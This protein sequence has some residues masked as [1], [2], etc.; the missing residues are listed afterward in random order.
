MKRAVLAI[1]ALVA[2]FA[3]ANAG[4]AA[5]QGTQNNALFAQSYA[6]NNVT[7]V[8]ATT[9]RVSCY[10]PEVTYFDSLAA[11]DGYPGG[12]MTPC[13]RATT[14]EQTQG[15]ATQDVS[16]PPMLVKD[17]SESD[18]R[19]DPGNPSHVIGTSK[20]FVSAEG[21]NHLLGFYESWDGGK[22]WP[23]QGHIPGY[24][25]W[26]DNT[27]PVGAF[28]PW[29]NFYVANLP[30]EFVYSKSGGHV[31]NNGSAQANPSLPPE[32]VSVAVRPAGAT[33]ATQWIS[34]HNGVP[35]FVWTSKNANTGTPDKQWITIDDNSASPFKGRAYVMF[36]DYVL[37]PSVPLLSY[38][39]TRRDGSHT[40][41]SPIQQL[42]TVN[43][44]RFDQYLLPHVAPDGTIYTPVN[45][46][47]QQQGFLNND[48]Y[49]D[50]STTGGAT[51]NG[52]TPIRSGVV[53]PTYQ[54]TTFSEGIVDTFAVG[55]HLVDGH[56]PLY[57][58]YENEDPDGLSHVYLIGSFDGGKTWT[59]SPIQV[60]DNGGSTEALQPNL[61]VAPDGSVS[62]A[63][64][65]RRLPC[66][67]KGTVQANA[68]GL[69]YDPNQPYGA[70]NYCVNTAIQFYTPTLAPIGHN[71][72]LSSQ[73][74]DPQLNSPK[75]YSIGGS[76]TFLG[77]YFG[78]D[79]GGGSTF[80]TSISTYDDGSNPN[81]YQQQVVAK[82]VT[83]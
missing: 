38:A 17:H 80:T 10:A 13:K 73:T 69:Q 24:E 35:D 19:V 49:L 11:A 75:R 74:W 77:D 67:A 42:P 25:G 37:N 83:P 36:V 26:T 14:G 65:D 66:P 46:N 16:N 9:Q 50:W 68:A 22:T 72:R 43:G 45:H 33:K 48:F 56:Y 79:S 4:A 60:N 20:W 1:V 40:D 15:F 53:T 71:V 78:V 18:I 8:D 39:Q 64:Y 27:D 21:Y 63:F 47:P 58:A 44:N 32:G 51:W 28:D 54:N 59:F 41:W 57:L 6:A 5:P 52:P 34:T 81:N 29:G 55:N 82:I 31:Y 76:T 70:V 3:A 23:S 61:N 12:G 2:A 7:S 62:V 30:Y